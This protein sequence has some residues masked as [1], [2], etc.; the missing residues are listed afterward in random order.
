M[1][2]VSGL[3][4]Y[5]Y[6][7]AQGIDIS[8]AN[9]TLDYTIKRPG[10]EA[11][12]YTVP[13]PIVDTEPFYTYICETCPTGNCPPDE[14]V[15]LSSH[16][17]EKVIFDYTF[18]TFGT[19]NLGQVEAGDTLMFAFSNGGVNSVTRFNLYDHQWYYEPESYDWVWGFTEFAYSGDNICD[20]HWR[21]EETSGGHSNPLRSRLRIEGP[22][23][24]ELEAISVDLDKDPSTYD[25]QPDS[26]ITAEATVAD[27]LP[28]FSIRFELGNHDPAD[29]VFTW[30]DGT[31]DP[32]TFTPDGNGMAQIAVKSTSYWGVARITAN[33]VSDQDSVVGSDWIEIPEDI[34]NDGIADWWED[35]QTATGIESDGSWDEDPNPDPDIVAVGDGISKLLEY[36]GVLIDGVHHR[37]TPDSMEVFFDVHNAGSGGLWAADTAIKQFGL[38]G[39][40]VEGLEMGNI[41]AP[42]EI[43]PGNTPLHWLGNTD[44]RTNFNLVSDSVLPHQGSGLSDREENDN[45]LYVA[46]GKYYWGDEVIDQGCKPV[47]DQLLKCQPRGSAGGPFLGD[48]ELISSARFGR[49]WV[50][51]GTIANLFDVGANWIH[52]SFTHTFFKSVATRICRLGCPRNYFSAVYD[53]SDFDELAGLNDVDPLELL[54]EH[55]DVYSN[56]KV[57]SLITGMSEADIAETTFLHEIGHLFNLAHD[58]RTYEASPMRTGFGPAKARVFTRADKHEFRLRPQ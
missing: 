8:L 22:P 50:Y 45:G 28:G 57:D 32:K 5:R 14:L 18:Y 36:Q 10:D 24:I 34:D 26:I 37:L 12:T 1:A 3:L 49:A 7:W 40:I 51:R 56:D 27:A 23:E 4:V 16:P 44:P 38:K 2:N 25:P 55:D 54:S 15:D 53:G 11:A 30:S 21:V 17:S 39:I 47:S 42:T 43:F 31:T 19:H 48:S 13:F 52:E 41:A 9:T 20:E 46:N 35:A 33:Y 58:R 6:T 29:P